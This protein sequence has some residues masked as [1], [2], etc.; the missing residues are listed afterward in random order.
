VGGVDLGGRGPVAD[1][2]GLAAPA[3]RSRGG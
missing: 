2:A 1:A 3:A